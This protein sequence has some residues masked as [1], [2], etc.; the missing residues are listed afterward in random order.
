MH[1]CGVGSRF[2]CFMREYLKIES[3]DF[4]NFLF[5]YIRGWKFDGFDVRYGVGI[6]PI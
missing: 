4:E 1:R 3:E 5:M 6:K 2:F